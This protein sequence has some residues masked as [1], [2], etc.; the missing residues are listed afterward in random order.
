MRIRKIALIG[1][2]CILQGHFTSVKNAFKSLVIFLNATILSLCISSNA[3]A[4][5]VN[6]AALTPGLKIA[7]AIFIMIVISF[8]VIDKTQFT[9]IIKESY[10][11]LI[12]GMSFK[13]RTDLESIIGF[14][15]LI[16][17][18]KAGQISETQKEFLENIISE[19]NNILGEVEKIESGNVSLKAILIT[20]PFKVRTSLNTVIGFANLLYNGKTGNVS[21]QQ[22][23]F[24]KNILSGSK[25]ILDSVEK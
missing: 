5:S 14:A 3:V 25:D 16:S 24:L 7:Y 12:A 18:S 9:I 21:E 17:D 20:L 1:I 15:K 2:K 22:K 11:K 8:I 23:L 13:M 6:N 19:A 10:R 4:N